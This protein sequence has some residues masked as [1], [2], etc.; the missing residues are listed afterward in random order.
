MCVCAKQF[1]H[2]WNQYKKGYAQYGSTSKAR[3][4]FKTA[5]KILNHSMEQEGGITFVCSEHCINEKLQLLAAIRAVLLLSAVYP[6]RLHQLAKVAGS[7]RKASCCPYNP[8]V[9]SWNLWEIKLFF[10]FLRLPFSD[11]FLWKTT[12][13]IGTL[14]SE[15]NGR[16]ELQHL[17]MNFLLGTISGHDA[18]SDLHHRENLPER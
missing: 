7:V 1:V 13:Y 14:T 12:N 5:F 10:Y 4:T 18:F 17:L 11:L 2:F 3:L 16:R 9:E 15:V 6:T 8:A